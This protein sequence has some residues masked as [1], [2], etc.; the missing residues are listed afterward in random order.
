AA[1][2]SSAPATA[3]PVVG[4]VATA[5]AALSA[6]SILSTSAAAEAN[7]SGATM[8][9]DTRASSVVSPVAA[10]HC[11][12]YRPRCDCLFSGSLSAPGTWPLPGEATHHVRTHELGRYFGVVHVQR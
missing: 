3:S 1:E 6:V 11:R 5:F 8:S 9:S 12:P 7:I 10:A 4:T 2:T